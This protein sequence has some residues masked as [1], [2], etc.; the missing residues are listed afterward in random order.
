MRLGDI[1]V[2]NRQGVVQYDFDKEELDGEV[3]KITPRHPPRPPSARLLES[4]RLLEAEEME[5]NRPWIQFI[6]LALEQLL[7]TRPPDETD[8][9]LSSTDPNQA[10]LHPTDPERLSGQPRV[11]SG[12]IASANILLKNPVKRDQLRDT[13]SVKAVEIEGA[14]I[15]DASWNAGIGY[16]TVRGIY[17]YC[18]KNRGN[19]WQKYAAVVATAYTRALLESTPSDLASSDG[20]KEEKTARLSSDQSWARLALAS[21]A[22][23]KFL[24]G[25]LQFPRSRQPELCHYAAALIEKYSYLLPPIIAPTEQVYVAKARQTLIENGC[26]FSPQAEHS[27]EPKTL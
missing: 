13:F 18:D 23:V 22:V 25:T 20:D 14:G 4:V 15:A 17:D 5:G 16:F 26:L 19:S 24:F 7:L 8:V 12:P 1:V 9:L 6:S 21:D 10:I 2:S 3:P 11:F 27:G